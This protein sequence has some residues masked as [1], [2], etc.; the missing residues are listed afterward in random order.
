MSSGIFGAPGMCCAPEMI[1]PIDMASDSSMFRTAAGD[2]LNRLYEAK[3]VWHF[4]HRWATY[5]SGATRL[6][7]PADKSEPSFTVTP[8]YWVRAEDVKA[9]LTDR[10][11]RGWLVGFRRLTDSRNERSAVFGVIPVSGVGHSFAVLERLGT[12]WYGYSLFSSQR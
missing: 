4:D 6:C 10:G 7:T 9:R 8:R 1:I 2:G 11:K 3:L 5:D 12:L